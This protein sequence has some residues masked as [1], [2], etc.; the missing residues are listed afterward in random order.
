MEDV[1]DVWIT[2]KDQEVN[3]ESW[4]VHDWLNDKGVTR[5]TPDFVLMRLKGEVEGVVMAAS[6]GNTGDRTAVR[7]GRVDADD[8]VLI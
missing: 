7:Y 5:E 1:E 6:R 3:V 4:K 2:Y 8:D